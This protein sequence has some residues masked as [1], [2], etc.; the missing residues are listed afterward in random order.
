MVAPLDDVVDL[1]TTTG[2]D[3]SGR[4]PGRGPRPRAAP[5]GITRDWRPTSSGRPF[6]SITIGITCASQ[7]SIRSDS[8]DSVPPK[9]SIAARAR[10]SRSSSATMMFRCG[11]RPPR[12]G[13]LGGRAVVE[14]VAAGVGQRFGLALRCGPV[15]VG[16]ERLGGGVDQVAMAS[17]MAAS[18]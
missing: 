1:R 8:G 13:D 11:R 2:A 18:A 9:S 10:R 17:N 16:G 12:I 7:H 4:S 5:L 14:D 15:V 6:P 3:R